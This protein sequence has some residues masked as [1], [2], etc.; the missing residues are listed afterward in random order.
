MKKCAEKLGVKKSGIGLWI[1]ESWDW[2]YPFSSALSLRIFSPK[3]EVFSLRSS[4]L[5]DELGP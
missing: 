3:P 1:E 5:V 2:F 4:F